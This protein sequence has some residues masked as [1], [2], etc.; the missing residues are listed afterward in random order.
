MRRIWAPTPP[1]FMFEDPSGM[2]YVDHTIIH[3]VL[4]VETGDVLWGICIFWD[5]NGCGDI[6]PSIICLRTNSTMVTQMQHVALVLQCRLGKI[7]AIPHLNSVKWQQAMTFQ[8]TSMATCQVSNTVRAPKK[9][10]FFFKF[11]TI[12]GQILG[13]SFQL[14]QE[15]QEEFT[16]GYPFS[17]EVVLTLICYNLASG[18]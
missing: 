8:E 10:I 15:L 6:H 11:A 5:G 16:F 17:K 9:A 2:N 18:L 1:N 14:K 13:W 3:N 4:L 7:L 12:A